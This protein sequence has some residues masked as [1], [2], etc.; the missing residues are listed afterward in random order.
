MKK[1]FLIL[2]QTTLF[3]TFAIAQISNAQVKQLLS[4]EQ[5]KYNLTNDDINDF[6]ITDQYTDKHNGVTHI[7]FKQRVNGIEI[8]EAASSLHLDKNGNMIVLNN[9]FVS[10]ASQKAILKTPVIGTQTALSNAAVHVQMN[11][12]NALSKT[13]LPMENN[14]LVIKDETVS[15]E[16]IKLR[17]QYVLLAGE[18]KLTYYVELFNNQTSDWWNVK[19]DANDG[20]IIGKDNW[21]VSCNFNNHSFARPYSFADLNIAQSDEPVKFAKAGTGTYNVLPLPIESPNHAPRQLVSG[22]PTPNG[23]PFG[24]HDTDGVTGD[25]YTITRGNNVFAYDDKANK[26][27]PGTSPNGGV[28]LNFDYSYSRDSFARSNLNAA[29]TNLFYINNVVHDIYYNYGFTEAAGNFQSNDYNKGGTAGDCVHAEAQDGGGTN[30]ANFSAPTDGQSGRMQMYLWPSAGWETFNV[31]YPNSIKSTYT[32]IPAAFGPKSFPSITQSLVL[33]QDSASVPATYNGCGNLQNRSALAG[34]IALVD[35]TTGTTCPYTTKVLNAQN[36]GA[37]AVI[38]IQNTTGSPTAMTGTAT[39]ITIPSFMISL[40][41]GNKLKGRLADTIVNV[42]IM[43]NKGDSIDG[44]MDNGVIIHESAHGV[45]IR[46]TGGPS[47]TTSCLGNSEQAGEGWSDFFALALTTRAT[48]KPDDVRGMATYV[49]NQ[50]V[51]G[52]GI[53]T[54]PFSRN[55]TINPF[56]YNSI[57]NWGYDVHY[58][59]SVWAAMLWDLYWNLIDKYGFST[60]FYNGT[61]GNNR[62]LQLVMDGLKLQPCSPG[63]VDSRNAILLADKQD[64]GNAD[65]AIIWTAFARRGLGYSASQGS[66]SSCTDGTEAYDMPPGVIKTGVNELAQSNTIL[67]SPNPSNGLFNILLPVS[68]TKAEMTIVD[69]TGKVVINRNVEAD[70]NGNVELQLDNINNGIYFISVNTGT[71]LLKSKLVIAK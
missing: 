30:N 10:N 64:Y 55:M 41:D 52:L 24:W 39:G 66:S 2:L 25:D 4:A 44:D 9:A 68:V 50:S 17:L 22:N 51:T 54:Y 6:V 21:T 32:A 71:S 1:Y 37:I 62:C 45:S 8:A 31:N 19:V 40:A 20:G 60:D 65:S 56:T 23:S 35:R 69:V 48:D 67:V 36:S 11:V 63:F 14:L 70:V 38:V 28:N 47:K 16:P 18:L 3:A 43:G 33:M 5:A 57:K 49:A 12:A 34:K 27:A 53:R 29:V 46:L 59:G 15:P 42:T 58:S 26:N 61:A 13:N 7:Y